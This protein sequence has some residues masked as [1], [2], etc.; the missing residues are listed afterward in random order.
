MAFFERLKEK[1]GDVIEI[2]KINNKINEEKRKIAANKAALAEHYW[3]KFENGE[4]LDDEA[5]ELCNAIVASNNAIQNYNQEIQ[6]IKEEPAQAPQPAPAA[7]QVTASASVQPA[8]P[9]AAPAAPP[10]QPV[11]APVE[12][13]TSDESWPCQNCGAILLAGKK[14][15]SECGSPNISPEPVKEESTSCRNC[16]SP[17]VEGKKFCSECGAKVAFE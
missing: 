4:L 15:C 13:V 1:T 5:T 3:S 2:T 12:A 9:P 11:V 14:F 6:K 10:T 17:L 7:T 16:G 8:S